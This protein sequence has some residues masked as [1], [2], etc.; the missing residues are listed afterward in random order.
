MSLISRGC[1]C[2]RNEGGRRGEGFEVDIEGVVVGGDSFVGNSVGKHQE[3][4]TVM[5]AAN[6]RRA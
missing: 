1:R 3:V 4:E 6:L 2:K 5:A